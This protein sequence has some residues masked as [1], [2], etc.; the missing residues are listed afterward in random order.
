MDAK[1]DA[2]QRDLAYSRARLD[3]AELRALEPAQLQ[4]RIRDLEGESA[5]TLRYR[6]NASRMSPN[7]GQQVE[8]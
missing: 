2:L 6:E 8:L 5:P 7:E 4:R 3:K 1:M